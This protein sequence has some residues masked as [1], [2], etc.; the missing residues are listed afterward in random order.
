MKNEGDS[1]LV[2][3]IVKGGAADKSGLLR[4]GDEIL[5]VNGIEMRSVCARSGV[6]GRLC[7]V[8]A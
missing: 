6:F 7:S 2:G 1:V 3:R 4:P 5:E 8:R